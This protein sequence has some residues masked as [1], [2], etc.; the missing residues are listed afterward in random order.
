M[1]TLRFRLQFYLITLLVII[2]F[3]TIAFKTIE[4][5]TLTEAFYFIIVTIATVGYGDIH[6]VTDAGR[7]LTIV[8]IVLGVGTFLGV[9]ANATELMLNR[10]EQQTIT[11]KINMLIGV[12]FSEAGTKLI[13]LFSDNDPNMETILDELQI[14]ASSKAHDFDMIQRHLA[15][16]PF[17]VKIAQLDLAGLCSF[18]QEKRGLL[19]GL[20]VNPT[21]LEH[22]HFTD[23][24]RAVFH[25][26]EELGYRK[27]F[28]N[29]PASDKEH[30]AGDIKRA[31]KRLVE[32]WVMY[33]KYLK[34]HYPYLFSLAVRM[35]PYNRSASPVVTSSSMIL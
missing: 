12:F 32:Q 4:G 28:E 16:Y 23:L 13:Q 9:V 34:V 7:L 8:L 17:D 26:T 10:R 14:R 31:Y 6:P 5:V 33:M 21:L 25:L 24:L 1:N 29:L 30:I 20:L 15:N 35:S 2:I 3:G 11:N 22:A 18:L 19:V 27:D